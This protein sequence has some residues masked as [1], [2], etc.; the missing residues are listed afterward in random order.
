MNYLRSDLLAF[1][2][3]PSEKQIKLVA[4]ALL[5]DRG[6]KHNCYIGILK[7]RLNLSYDRF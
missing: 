2:I 6:L 7:V 4:I 1:K 3:P 5:G